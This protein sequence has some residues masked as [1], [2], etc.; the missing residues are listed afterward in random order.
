MPRGLP[1]CRRRWQSPARGARCWRYGRSRIQARPRSCAAS[2]SGLPPRRT[3][4]PRRCVRPSST[5]SLDASPAPTAR[6]TGRRSCSSGIE[7]SRFATGGR[8]HGRRGLDNGRGGILY[9]GDPRLAVE[10]VAVIGG[11]AGG[12]ESLPGN[13]RRIVDPGLFRL[14]VAARGLTLVDDVAA[15]LLQAA[16]DI[17]QLFLALDL[18]AEMVEP[19]PLAARGDR[20]VDAR[21]IEHPLG[22]IGLYDRRSRRE[23]GR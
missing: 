19:G 15:G 7:W 6:T 13:S 18:D 9:V 10:A 4:M 5:P 14:G 2:T 21:I 8:L 12:E 3:T 11:L 20:E 16:V 17:L 22:I 23:Q 1:V